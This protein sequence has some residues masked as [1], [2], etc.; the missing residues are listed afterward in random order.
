MPVAVRTRKGSKKGEKHRRASAV[1]ID[2]SL[3]ETEGVTTPGRGSGKAA[4]AVVAFQITRPSMADYP[5]RT[6]SGGGPAP[7]PVQKK[8]RRRIPP[9]DRGID[10]P[11]PRYRSQPGARVGDEVPARC[12]MR[13]RER[14]TQPTSRISPRAALRAVARFIRATR[15]KA[16]GGQPL[17]S[18]TRR[19]IATLPP[20]R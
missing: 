14:R 8:Y 9:L 6:P 19:G 10:I 3:P 13:D 17:A 7:T 1:V 12:A 11:R 16:G 18:H 5:I 4:H 15:R 2:T 20:L